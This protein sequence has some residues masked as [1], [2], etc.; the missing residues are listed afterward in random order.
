MAWTR[1]RCAE[2]RQAKARRQGPV[3][4]WCL[5][6][7]SPTVIVHLAGFHQPEVGAMGGEDQLVDPRVGLVGRV[8]GWEPRGSAEGL[9]RLS[10]CD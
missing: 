2:G 3:L 7:I 8:E 1:D 5:Q 4:Q 10:M 6:F 9:G